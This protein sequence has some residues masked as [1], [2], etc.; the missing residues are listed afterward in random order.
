MGK[1]VILMNVEKTYNYLWKQHMMARRI[2]ISRYGDGE[3][4]IMLGSKKDVATHKSS[5]KLTELMNRSIKRKGQLIC[6]PT[7]SIES[8][9]VRGNAANYFLEN[10]DHSRFGTGIWRL[11]DVQH[12]FNLLTEFFI[13]KTLIVTGNHVECKRAFKSNSID[14]DILEGRKINA[15]LDYEKLKKNLIRIARGY[16]NIIFALGPTSNILIA[17]LVGVCKSNLID[18]GGF[19]GP[20][21]NPYSKDENLVKKWTGIPRRSNKETMKRYSKRF[22]KK[23]QD[24]IELYS[25]L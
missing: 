21:I 13:D 24:K 18:I 20:I 15:F 19:I 16:D 6:M 3:Y 10:S 1:N 23:L 25:L 14:V 8:D 4:L 11:Y 17:D 12:D 5:E 22:F 2:V 9:G 7:T